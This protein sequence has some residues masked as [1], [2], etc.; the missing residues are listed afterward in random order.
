[1]GYKNMLF[2]VM[3]LN[4][5][6][7]LIELAQERFEKPLEACSNEEIYSLILILMKRILEVSERNTGEKK[8]Y[9]IS[10]EF[11]TGRLL[12]NN[13]VNLGLCGKLSDILEKYGK[14][15]SE[16]EECEPEPALGSGELGRLSAC[17]MD[18]IATA[19]FN[20]E[21][22][23][24]N[25]H[26]GMFRQV[27]ED[28]VQREEKDVWSRGKSWETGTGLSFDVW[29]GDRKVTSRM[30]EMS[31][32]GMGGATNK[33]RLFDLESVD[34]SLVERGIIFDKEDIARNLT[35]FMYPDDSDEKGRLLRLYQQYFLVCNSAQLILREMKARK[36][37]LRRLSEYAVIQINGTHS[38]LIIPEMIRILS[39]EK[40][41]TF[42]EAVKVVT[43]ACA[44]TNHTVLAESME[45]WALQEIEEVIPQLV[46]IIQRLDAFV[47]QQYPDRP[48]VWIVDN[49][50]DVHMTRMCIHYGFSVNGVSKVHTKVLEKATLK[51]FYDI[52]GFKFHNISNGISFRRWLIACNRPLTERICEEIG[53]DFQKDPS[54]LQALATTGDEK[55]LNDLWNIKANAKHELFELIKEREHV[56]L[57]P[58]GIYDMHV[59]RIHG[60]KR[61]LMGA[62]YIIHK[63]LE[64]KRG[65]IPK[66]PINF[67]FG[68]KAAPAYVFA[69]N[70]I[71]LLLVLQQLVNNDP[72]VNRWMRVVMVTNY[73]VEY[74]EKLIPACDVSEQISLASKEASGTI[75]MKMMLNGAVILGTKDGSNEEILEHVGA[76]NIYLF[77]ADAK[78]VVGHESR[79]DYSPQNYYHRV[80]MIRE[81]VDFITSETMLAIGQREPLEQLSAY[82][83]EWDRFMILLDFEDYIYVK[84]GML[85]DY[86]DQHNWKRKMLAGI[87]NSGYFSSDRT[88]ADYNREIWELKMRAN[89]T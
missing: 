59:T 84:D 19:G 47:K 34:D 86:E 10:A 44:Y 11:L 75:G 1:M 9:Y 15:L 87:A 46:P 66:R 70:V 67:I 77:G 36:Y 78:S 2:D 53:N 39:E 42:Y 56:N 29:F 85:E 7:Q 8:L 62:L 55:L 21:G 31:I 68:G 3:V 54:L 6:P 60:Q 45:R 83:R 23:S 57:I 58:N 80:D 74:A 27:F 52:Y 76:E 41:L 72:D 71:H 24:L 16:I 17:V 32:C 20:A 25:Y 4:M 69:K 37:N 14:H 35:L 88:V 64:I 82:L 79:R 48:D 30:Y 49:Q 51:E 28:L 89:Y 73:N 65:K 81:A 12:T 33:I 22:I 13:L 18:S 26:Y 63:Y 50:N 5:E 61:Q 38:S 43:A 40:G